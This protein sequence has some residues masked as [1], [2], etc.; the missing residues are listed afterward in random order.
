MCVCLCGTERDEVYF[1]M[2]CCCG[3]CGGGGGVEYMLGVFN[4]ALSTLLAN[5]IYC[6]Y[7]YILLI[8]ILFHFICFVLFYL[9]VWFGLVACYAAF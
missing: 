2:C 3:G 6:F 8:F 9:S 5:S 4:A 7:I 1:I